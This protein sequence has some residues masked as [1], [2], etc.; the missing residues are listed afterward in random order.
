MKKKKLKNI[1]TIICLTLFAFC[2]SIGF[3]SCNDDSEQSS[4]SACRH[5]VGD[6]GICT[7][8][9]EYIPT[10]GVL[11]QISDDGTSAEVCGYEGTDSVVVLAKEYQGLPVTTVATWVFQ[12][13]DNISRVVL[14]DS[15]TTLNG[16]AFSS[17]SNMTSI[18]LGENITTIEDF[19]FS[20]CFRLVEIYNKSSLSITANG[21]E[22]GK[23]DY[24]AKNVY[25]EP[26]GSKLVTDENGYVIYSDGEEKELISYIGTETD[27][28]LPENITKINDYAFHNMD[29]ITSVVIG[30][31][32]TEIGKYAFSICDL[33]QTVTVGDGVISI[34]SEAFAYCTSLNE[35]V[36]GKNLS[37]I[38]EWAFESCSKL[39]SITVD[40]ENSTYT[41]ID[42]NLYT[43]DGKK[44]LQYAIGKPE[45][46]VTIPDN[47]TVIGVGAFQYCETI[48]D[49]IIGD[50]VLVV[51]DWAFADCKNLTSISFG[52]NVGFI[53]DIAFDNTRL[54]NITV[55]ENN[56]EYTAEDNVLYFFANG[57][58]YLQLYAARNTSETFTVSDDV[59][60][61]SRYAFENC[62]YLRKVTIGQNVN[63]IFAYAFVSCKNL[64]DVEIKNADTVIDKNAFYG[65][66]NLTDIT[67]L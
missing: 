22:P 44:L 17:C 40:G 33:L 30:E 66:E 23:V 50:N 10:D 36:F 64:V 1:A 52:K 11:Y 5:N 39:K 18:V 48:T 54:L 28:A 9:E 37:T 20:A 51:D 62:D 47:V 29:K 26:T 58:K 59:V 53:S 6:D 41:S 7:L 67:I 24:Y 35:L 61:I 42:G 46:T 56:P 32:V 14:G 63:T 12:D 57:K 55:D 65:C 43:K 34:G 27:L 31:Q 3:V 45:T 8:C 16:W 2:M 60:Y 13:C 15:I 25:T 38:G 49:V 19:A 4:E 21:E